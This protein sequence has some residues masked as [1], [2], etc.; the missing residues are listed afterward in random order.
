MRPMFVWSLV[1]AAALP[2][3]PASA[4][5]PPLPSVDSSTVI[6]F[7]RTKGSNVVG[8]VVAA[9]DSALTVITLKSAQVVLPRRSVDSWH[10]RRGTFTARGF[11]DTDLHTSRLFFGPTARTLERGGGYVAAYDVFIF[12]GAYGVSDR[13]M[14]SLGGSMLENEKGV[15]DG[16]S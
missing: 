2:P 6:M 8:R 15:H 5:R 9:D 4:Q 3:L 10:V 12:A 14:F 13:V 11:R 7:Y 1:V 16:P